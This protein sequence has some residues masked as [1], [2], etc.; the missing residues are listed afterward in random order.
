MLTGMIETVGERLK[1]A[2]EAAGLSQ[3][4][5]AEQIGATRSAI[6]QVEGGLSNSLNA[7]NLAK[8]ARKLGKTAVWLATGEGPESSSEV[9]SD[10]LSA[11]NDDDRQAAFDFILYK[12]DRASPAYIAQ[13]RAHHYTDM[14]ERLKSDMRNRKSE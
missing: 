3:Q 10:A 5:L 8:A 6:A 2:R 9:L 13:E 1:K 11:L 4:Q 14:I 12:I 7:E